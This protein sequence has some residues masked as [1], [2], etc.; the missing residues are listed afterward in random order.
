[1]SIESEK[2]R[3]SQQETLELLRRRMA[4]TEMVTVCYS[5]QDNG[6]HYAIYCAL[7]P[8]A[9]RASLGQLPVGSF[10]RG[11]NAGRIG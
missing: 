6:G 1:M 10:P 4:L 8:A 7:L 3:L 9:D 2:E 11:S 5:E